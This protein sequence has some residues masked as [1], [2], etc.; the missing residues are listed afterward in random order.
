MKGLKEI[1]VGSAFGVAIVA[2]FAVIYLSIGYYIIDNEL[3]KFG[4]DY[5]RFYTKK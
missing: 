2:L 4:N 5:Y 3:Q 1:K